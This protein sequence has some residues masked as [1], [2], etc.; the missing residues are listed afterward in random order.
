[1]GDKSAGYGTCSLAIAQTPACDTH[2]SQCVSCPSHSQ[3]GSRSGQGASSHCPLSLKGPAKE[4]L[5]PGTR[6]FQE[7][8][9]SLS[10]E[11]RKGMGSTGWGVSGPGVGQIQIAPPMFINQNS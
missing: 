6:G 11:G 10:Q 1:M 7:H 5:S 2:A 3:G 4:G 8:V 9:G